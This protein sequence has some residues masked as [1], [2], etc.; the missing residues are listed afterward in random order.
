MPNIHI[1][2]GCSF[3]VAATQSS[4]H[5]I[6]DQSKQAIDSSCTSR[7]T[8]FEQTFYSYVWEFLSP[9]LQETMLLLLALKGGA[10]WVVPLYLRSIHS[11]KESSVHSESLSWGQKFC[12]TRNPSVT[13]SWRVPGVQQTVGPLFA[14]CSRIVWYWLVEVPLVDGKNI[15]WPRRVSALLKRCWSYGLSREMQVW[16]MQLAKRTGWNMM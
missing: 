1:W 15:V 2:N 5:C 6:W 11:G 7:E 12:M 10:F 13:G 14:R 8:N 9:T 4:W 16:T 3:E